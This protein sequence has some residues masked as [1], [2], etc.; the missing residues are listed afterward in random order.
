M[1]HALIFGGNGRIARAMTKLLLARSWTVT[2]IIRNPRQEAGIFSLGEGQPGKV[3][4]L[5]YDLSDLKTAQDA[6]ELFT[7]S[8]ADCGVFAAGSFTNVYGIDRDAAKSAIAAATTLP[9][10]TKFLMISFPASRRK[11]APWWNEKDIA[12]YTSEQNAYPEIG[13]AKMQADE[14]FVAMAH[15]RRRRDGAK[16]NSDSTFQAISLRPTWL[17][18]GKGT[19]RI[20]LGKT[21]ALGT[22][23]IEDV[24]GV[25]AEMLSRDDVS[26]WFD[27]VQGGEGIAE[28]VEGVVRGGVD[29]VEGEDLE[30]MYS[31]ADLEEIR[32]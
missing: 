26:G 12:D 20:S 4:V 16:S 14:Y 25:A 3:Q 5:Y 11:P 10:V 1:M 29:C 17:T 13:D 21:R 2:S 8:G 23:A 6:E 19:G 22:V 7:R 15:A 24:A 27:L 31:L 9:T 30:G 32:H 18:M 28:A